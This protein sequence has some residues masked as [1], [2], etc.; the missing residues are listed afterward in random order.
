MTLESNASKVE[1][2]VA[3]ALD[4][5][6]QAA[7][8]KIINEVNQDLSKMSTPEKSYVEND[9]QAKGVLP[10]LAIKTG[11]VAEDEYVTKE[12]LT[13]LGESEGPDSVKGM[14][15]RYLAENFETIAGNRQDIDA[16][17][18]E[19]FDG[20]IDLAVET[21]QAMREMPGLMTLAKAGLTETDASAKDGLDAKD[22][23]NLL[24]KPENLSED[25]KKAL[26]FMQSKFDLMKTPRGIWRATDWSTP[27]ITAESLDEFVDTSV[28]LG[29]RKQLEIVQK[30]YGESA[31]LKEEAEKA[32]TPDPAGDGTQDKVE[33][34]PA[35]DGKDAGQDQSQ[36]QLTPGDPQD[37]GQTD[38]DRAKDPNELGPDRRT[39]E[40]K[41]QIVPGDTTGNGN[42]V[43]PQGAK[44]QDNLPRDANPDEFGPDRRVPQDESS[45]QT[46]SDRTKHFR[47]FGEPESPGDKPQ[48]GEQPPEKAQEQD[49]FKTIK[50]KEGA[51]VQDFARSQLGQD[52]SDDDVRA[53]TEKIVNAN[54]SLDGAQ[55]NIEAGAEIRVPQELELRPVDRVYEVKPGDNLWNISKSHLQEK[56]GTRPSNQE[57][58]D[59]VNKIVE[60][61]SIPNPDLIYPDQKIIIPGEVPEEVEPP[62]EAAPPAE[63]EESDAKKKLLEEAEAKFGDEP[64]KFE[65]FKKDM[66]TFEARKERDGI[67]DGDIDNTYK[68]VTRL[69]EAEGDTP[70]NQEQR[71]KLAQ[72]IMFQAANPN[73]IDQ[74]TNNTCNMNTVEVKTYTKQ[75]AAAAKLVVDVATTGKYTTTDG[76]TVE[77]DPTP[78]GQSKN[79]VKFDG[80]RSHASEIF[81]V[82]GVNLHLNIENNKTDP[83][84]QLRYEQHDPVPGVRGGG[85][86]L[87]D[88]STTPPT[89]KGTSPGVTVGNLHNLRDVYK[90]ITGV[91]ERENILGHENFVTDTSDAVKRISSEE[92]LTAYLTQA[93]ADGKFPVTVAVETTNEPFWSDSGGGVAG[94]SGGGHVLNITDFEPGPPGKVAIDN[95]WGTDDDHDASDPVSVHDLYIA[96]QRP[97]DSVDIIRE[98]VRASREGGSPDHWREFELLRVERNLGETDNEQYAEKL[99]ESMATAK[100]DWDAGKS[101]EGKDRALEKL[102]ELI[103]SLPA[104]QR[105]ELTEYR[106]SL[107]I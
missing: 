67:T 63:P 1:H 78:H 25:Q 85:E 94:G 95:S 36:G 10:D 72:Q 79:P 96:M 8:Q 39:E 65:D 15:A 104:A 27:R 16:N 56:S 5:S 30:D 47:N 6:D 42:D 44:L 92:E 17:D 50:L 11:V 7:S 70:I 62:P 49:P 93:K 57:V 74:G 26:E 18:V 91:E 24:A 58:L 77:I 32:I 83:P 59:M 69:L 60:R 98:D 81:Q 19:G 71:E 55:A 34:K 101:L 64:E 76:V 21:V 100:G 90:Q 41:S 22:I 105:T 99:K 84:G 86:K 102:G 68:E 45:Y 82:T 3:S 2:G 51:T 40:E 38:E 33:P 20:R 97:R 37:K 23:E 28:P 35:E 4:T 75:P 88:Y 13:K 54:D 12:D 48:E 103:R 106:A 29:F 53:L 14:A 89:E 43:G 61:N 80:A 87:M 66:E 107:G 46:V 73:Q 52:A 31:G 9:L